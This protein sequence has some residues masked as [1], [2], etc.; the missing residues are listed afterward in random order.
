MALNAE[1][2]ATEQTRI[3]LLIYM[4]YEPKLKEPGNGPSTILIDH[5]RQND[6]LKNKIDVR[7]FPQVSKNTTR[8]KT[9]QTNCNVME[10]EGHLFPQSTIGFSFP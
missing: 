3:S 7:V 2:R 9:R 1:A 5:Q 4:N 6:I 10:K 8:C